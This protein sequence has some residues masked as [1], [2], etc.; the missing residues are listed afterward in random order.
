[1]PTFA[2]LTKAKLP[3]DRILDGHSFVP[4]IFGKKGNPRNWIYQ[5]WKGKGWIRTK[6]WKLYNTGHLFDMK[7]D[8]LEKHAIDVEDKTEKSSNI[9]DYLTKE[10]HKLKDSAE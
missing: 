6:E 9:R 1:L 3:E 7:N 5:E 8:P 4:Q 2:E 10:L